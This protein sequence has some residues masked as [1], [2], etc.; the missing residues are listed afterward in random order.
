VKII[1]VNIFICFI[2]LLLLL[3]VGVDVVDDLGDVD[4]LH[5]G[6]DHCLGPR[7]LL[8]ADGQGDGRLALAGSLFCR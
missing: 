2:Y 4:A 8:V 3:L 6:V 1:I 7:L 5:E